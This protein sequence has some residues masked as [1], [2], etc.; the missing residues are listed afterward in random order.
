MFHKNRG[1]TLV[2]VLTLAFGIGANTAI[3]SVINAVLLRPLPIEESD[4]LVWM[5]ERHEQIPIRMISYPNFLDWR[6]RTRSFEAMA[7][8]RGWPTTLTG[9]GE[10]Q[11]LTARLVTANYF[12]VMRAHPLLGRDF[13]GEEDRFGAPSVTILSHGFWQRQFG[14]DQNILGKSITLG[15]QPF[16]VI[17]VMPDSF[18]HSE[19][20]AVPSLWLLVGQRAEPGGGWFERD[21]RIAGFVVA[22]LKAGV[23]LEQA[24]S[25]MNLISEQLIKE[26]PMRNGGHTISVVSLQESL[27]GGV[28]QVLWMLLVA[29][30]LVLLIACANVSN[31]LLARS[32]GRQREFA[33]RTALGADR[34][35]IARQ[36]L[37]ESVLLAV[38]GGALGVLLAWW[39]VGLIVAVEPQG[40]PRIAGAAVGGPVLGFA[41]TLSMLTGVVFG[42]APAW[43]T[44]RRDLRASLNDGSRQT[45]E[46][47][48]RLR[49]AL[50]VAEVALALILL[51]GAGL[52]LRSFARLL[53]SHPGFDPQNVLTMR[54]S[55]RDAYTSRE[56][57]TQF[58]SQLL[59]RVRALPGIEAASVLNDLPG[60]D[61]AWQTDINPEAGNPEINGG[62]LKIKPGELINVDWGIITADYFKTMR[63][64][65]KQGRTF[66][67]Q[68]VEQGGNVLLVD[69][70]LARR[71]WPRGDAL[72]RHIKYDAHGP[73][74]IIGIVGDVRNY[75]SEAPGRIKIYTPFGRMPLSHSALAVRSAGIDPLDLVAAIKHEVAA[76]N[77]N[78]PASEIATL[79]DRLSHRV[80]PR[81]INTILVTAFGALALI[82]AAVG[83]YG[84]MSHSVTARTHE[85]GIRMALGAQPR[86]VLKLAVKQ[87]MT[88]ALSGMAIGLTA[89]FAL[90]RLMKS[91]L[92]GV[93]ATDPLTFA[94]IVSLLTI[95]VFLACWIPA[96]RATKVDP[97][98]ALRN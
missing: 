4:R 88:L 79:N 3:F 68:E 44:A 85:F 64:T 27:V 18:R 82:L 83:I 62:Y 60:L 86:D 21:T 89:S 74:E 24:R 91:L 30:G 84:V 73:Q 45:G 17:G 28:R 65:I 5:S 43:Q 42:I 50:V 13:T 46:R 69:E 80:A 33:I 55:P 6:A 98:A 87:G 31:L 92:F 76:I 29:V 63:I 12:R 11:S 10:A 72:G 32:A 23:S 67:Q 8:T 70:Q 53:D 97:L 77:P 90:T 47:G 54:L 59:A 39:L 34:W 41:F 22:R 56:R 19:L 75:D 93:G 78:V 37:V 2:A 38:A 15:N 16:T 52:L 26:H 25:E 96:R 9:A 95:V 57:L 20:G 81:R 1:F 40:V 51:V 14:G 58:H 94:A 35:R 66:T 48:G 7:T 71:F 61:P 49:G 36:L